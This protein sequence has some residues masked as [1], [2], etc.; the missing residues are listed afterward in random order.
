[1]TSG[2]YVVS[3]ETLKIPRQAVQFISYIGANVAELIVVDSHKEDIT[4]RL[5]AAGVQHDPSF[6][7]LSPRSFT[8]A[9]TIER[10]GLTTKSEAEGSKAAKQA[11]ISRMESML[12]VIAGHRLGL[13]SFVRSL[14]NAVEDGIPHCPLL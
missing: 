7:P 8:D 13:R 14:R 10:L 2:R 5:A 1:M 3:F 11:F 6:D 4:R 9:A 12:S